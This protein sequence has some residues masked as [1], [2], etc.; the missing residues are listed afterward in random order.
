MRFLTFMLPP[1]E[2]GP[3]GP[4]PEATSSL[5]IFQKRTPRQ[6]VVWVSI[7]ALTFAVTACNTSDTPVAEPEDLTAAADSAQRVAWGEL[8]VVRTDSI[9]PS[10]FFDTTYKYLLQAVLVEREKRMIADSFARKTVLAVDRLQTKQQRDNGLLAIREMES[11]DSLWTIR[12]DS[13][14]GLYIASAGAYLDSARV[15]SS[16]K[17][18][19]IAKLTSTNRFIPAWRV[20]LDSLTRETLRVQRE[21]I[22][23]IDTASRRI[24]IEGALQFS[25]PGDM[26]TYQAFTARLEQLAIDQSAAMD[27]SLGI[28]G[29]QPV[30]S[31]ATPG[32]TPA[33][34][35]QPPVRTWPQAV[36]VR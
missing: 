2:N 11:R 25:E 21:I 14:R 23:F 18:E 5:R 12:L 8:Q 7:L 15:D 10:A 32:Q 29:A 35:V 4:G 19:I 17:R 30:D 28:N 3:A 9:R 27:R 24:K 6:V 1:E 22:H 20:E 33:P 31:A 16:D 26:T 34:P 36:R 13:L